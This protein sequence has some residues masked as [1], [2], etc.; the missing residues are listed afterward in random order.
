MDPNW[1]NFTKNVSHLNNAGKEL[2][3]KLIVTQ[4]NKHINS[5]GR[6]E[7]AIALNW[8]EETTNKSTN[9]TDNQMPNLLTADDRLLE[10]PIPPNQVYNN[11]GCSSLGQIL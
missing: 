9:V 11:Q 4:I 8:K 6:N 5:I 1:K 2:F 3:A 10:V 7:L